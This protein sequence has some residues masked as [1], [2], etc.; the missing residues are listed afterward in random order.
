[1][2]ARP[3]VEPR[4][5]RLR[6]FAAALARYDALPRAPWTREKHELHAKIVALIEAEGRIRHAGYLFVPWL[7][8][9]RRVQI[10]PPAR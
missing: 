6:R 8:G 2:P 10:K 3:R 5:A 4:S 9:F 1:M 7:D